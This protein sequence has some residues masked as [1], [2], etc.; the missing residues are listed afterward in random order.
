MLAVVDELQVRAATDTEGARH[1]FGG[2]VDAEL[3]LAG[4]EVEGL[5]RHARVTG[6][7][8]AVGLAAHAAMAMGQSVDGGVDTVAHDTTQ[9]LAGV[10]LHGSSLQLQAS[11]KLPALAMLR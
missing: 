3:V 5:Q 9:A 7:R 10:G 4:H 8:G 6:E 1:V 2:V 11:V